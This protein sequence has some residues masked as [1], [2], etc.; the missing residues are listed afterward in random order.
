[1]FLSPVVKPLTFIYLKRLQDQ[2]SL[3][4]F[5]LI[6][7]DKTFRK[8]S[9]KSFYPAVF[10]PYCQKLKLNTKACIIWLKQSCGNHVRVYV[11]LWC[12]THRLLLM[13]NQPQ[14]AN[15]ERMKKKLWPHEGRKLQ[16]KEFQSSDVQQEEEQQ[17]G[18]GEEFSKKTGSP[19]NKE[20]EA[21]PGAE[22]TQIGNRKQSRSKSKAIF[23]ILMF[24]CLKLEH[25]N[26]VIVNMSHIQCP[27]TQTNSFL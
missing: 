5:C 11:T 15:C 27:V 12:R 14:Q 19:R 3:T 1:M 9:S 4:S 21:T 16:I 17:A 6:D 2:R 25:F 7:E 8:L 26:S 24:Y 22:E 13:K 10:A 23:L 18:R 20:R